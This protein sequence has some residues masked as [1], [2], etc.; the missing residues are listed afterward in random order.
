MGGHGPKGSGLAAKGEEGGRCF[1][2]PKR[3][4]GRATRLGDER[5]QV[6]I[7]Q[8][9]VGY[10]NMH[11]DRARG[12]ACQGRERDKSWSCVGSSHACITTPK[13][14]LGRATRLGDE[15]G[16]VR[17]T[18]RRVG[19]ANMHHDRARG[20]ACR[21]RERDR[22]WSC[23]GFSHACIT[24]PKRTLGRA[25]RLARNAKRKQPSLSPRAR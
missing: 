17:I 13:R 10:A 23:V 16:Q 1:T 6:R 21:G 22:S 5:G 11:H 4:L 24:T 18:Q 7:T 3:T 8:R 9:R 20:L 25:T 15:R 19:Y 2:T 12:L 14:T